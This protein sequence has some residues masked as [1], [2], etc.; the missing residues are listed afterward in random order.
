MKNSLKILICAMLVFSLFASVSVAAPY[1]GR[2]KELKDYSVVEKAKI[3]SAAKDKFNYVI[4]DKVR[5]DKK[6]NISVV[7]EE[8]KLKFK[9]SSG[10]HEV[11]NLQVS[12][13][14]I[15]PYI[16]NGA[17]R[18]EHKNDAGI[19]DAVWIQEVE[20]DD[21]FVYLVDIP[22]SEVVVGGFTG[23][24]TKTSNMTYNTSS[25][26]L[27]GA[28]F[29]TSMLDTLTVTVSPH[30]TETSPYDIPTNGL[31][32][33]WKFDEGS[34]IYVNDSSGNN[35]NGTASGGMTWTDGKYNSAGSFDGKDDFV[36]ANAVN[37]KNLTVISTVKFKSLTPVS[38]VFVRCGDVPSSLNLYYTGTELCNTYTV[39]GTWTGINYPWA[40][41]LNKSYCIV[42]TREF[43]NTTATLKLYIDGVCVETGTCEGNPDNGSS[44][45][46]G[47]VNGTLGMFNGSL[48]NVMIYNR[49]LNNTEIAQIYYD[50]I[51]DLQFK[52]NSNT[53][54][55]SQL[56]VSGSVSVPY[57]SEDSEVSSLSAYVPEIVTI[58]GITVRD[59]RK[60][61]SPFTLSAVYGFTENTTLV[62]EKAYA[63]QY[64]LNISFIPTKE[65]SSGELTFTTDLLGTDW[66]G[67]LILDSNDI[68]SSVNFNPV[69]Q[70]FTITTGALTAAETYNYNIS[71]NY[72]NI[73]IASFEVDSVTGYVPCKI[74]FTDTS[75]NVDTLTSYL[76]NF[77]DG[78][79]STEK[80][81]EH[82][83]NEPGVY[84]V[85]LKVTNPAGEDT[86]IKTNLVSVEDFKENIERDGVSPIW[87]TAIGM[88]F[89]CV[90]I[91]FA[92]LMAGAMKGK[93]TPDIIIGAASSLVVIL[94]TVLVGS[95]ILSAF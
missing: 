74:S 33:W 26:Q 45:Y 76:W 14:L 88:I 73:P 38:R 21:G 54:Y 22:F 11:H 66:T 4:N 50:N 18:I 57:D 70:K 79:L 72:V 59:Y 49:A 86:E 25:V 90:I 46:F 47:S 78:H 9:S 5:T 75:S 64:N 51:E 19:T 91:V 61:I 83:Y 37:S 29:T 60:T 16:V 95:I 48:D 1:D 85:T 53:T 12:Y 52:T 36:T 58:S 87:V 6:A 28:N 2:L 35:N 34:G 62:E 92:S 40:P 27:A 89:A 65:V 10:K 82:T 68:N 67:N 63:G 43:N 93:A 84:T 3:N 81:P 56:D 32:G 69:T 41:E 77:G 44:L 80:N 15:S 94:V 13:D 31:V 17:V 20:N 24:Y 42:A 30:Y 7:T 71:L 39:N 55:S 23:T 8:N